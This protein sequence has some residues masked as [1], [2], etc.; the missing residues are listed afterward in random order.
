MV[1]LCYFSSL[2][3]M[4]ISLCSSD[5]C[6]GLASFRGVNPLTLPF[7]DTVNTSGF[8]LWN[9]SRLMLML[10]ETDYG[11]IPLVLILTHTYANTHTPLSL[12]PLDFY[13]IKVALCLAPMKLI[14]CCEINRGLRGC[15]GWVRGF[16]GPF[17]LRTHLDVAKNVFLINRSIRQSGWR[18]KKKDNNS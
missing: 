6:A 15:G 12:P 18:E 16:Q 8:C 17:E 13:C 14:F 3:L 11:I 7:S 1:L 10:W 5:V 2:M 9:N 4:L